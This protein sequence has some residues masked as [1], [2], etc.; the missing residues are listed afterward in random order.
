MTIRLDTE[1]TRR[2]AQEAARAA[3]HQ[4]L[5]PGLDRTLASEKAQA[6]SLEICRDYVVLRSIEQG[7]AVAAVGSAAGIG[8][9]TG[10]ELRKHLTAQQ[11]G[12]ADAFGLDPEGRRIS[13]S[14]RYDGSL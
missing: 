13:S 11:E 1:D 7:D 4:A 3:C 10:L 5:G 8:V 2:L 6:A 12:R 14:G 9:A